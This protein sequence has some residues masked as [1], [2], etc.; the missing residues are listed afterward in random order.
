MEFVLY[1]M[2]AII[3]TVIGRVLYRKRLKHSARYQMGRD[4]EGWSEAYDQIIYTQDNSSAMTYGLWSIPFWP[5]TLAFWLV[6][7]PTPEEKRY[8]RTAQL[9]RDMAEAQRLLTEAERA[10]TLETSKKG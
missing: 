8:Q 4:V 9:K 10:L 3:G 7:A 5:V 1:A 6:L 2:Y